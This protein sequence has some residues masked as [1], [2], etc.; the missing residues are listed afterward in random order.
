MDWHGNH[1]LI[2]STLIIIVVVVVI[3]IHRNREKSLNWNRVVSGA[4]GRHWNAVISH[5]ITVTLSVT[6][7]YALGVTLLHTKCDVNLSITHFYSVISC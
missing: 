5:S 4:G 1:I 6:H 3:A 2:I 7:C